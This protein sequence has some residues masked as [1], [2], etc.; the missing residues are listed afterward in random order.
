MGKKQRNLVGIR[1]GNLVVL[2]SCGVG[3]DR[4]YYSKVRCDCG[5]EYMVPDTELLHNRRKKCKSC[6]K[7]R[8][9]HGMSKTRL[10]TIWQSMKQ[11]CC[12]KNHCNYRHYG[13]RGIRVCKE[14]SNSFEKFYCW[15][16]ESGYNNSLTIERINVNGNYSPDNCKWISKNEQANNKRNNHLVDYKGGKYTISQLSEISGISYMCLYNRISNG[17]DIEKAIT[18]I[19]ELGRNQYEKI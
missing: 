16:K 14:W 3:D 12:D 15:A 2:E 18:T 11:R 17:W 4:H 6:S 13:G 5:K 8:K 7:P 19:P 9:T 1:F 10:F